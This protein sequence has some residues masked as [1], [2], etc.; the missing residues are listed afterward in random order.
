MNCHLVGIAYGYSMSVRFIFIGIVF[1]IGSKITVDNK[2]DSQDVFLSIY[3]IFTAAMG[4]GFAMSSVPSATQAKESAATIFSMIDDKSQLDARDYKGKL[5]EVPNGTI[6]FK[7]IN[8]NYPSRKKKVLEGFNMVIP[9]GK[10]IGLVGHS[11]CGK[12]TIT[13]LLLRFYDVKD[14]DVLIDGENINKYDISEL[15]RQ[16][17]FV[18]QEPILFNTSIKE[19]IL[20]GKMDATDGQVR[21]Y[22]E[23][24]N[25]LQFIES[26]YEDLTE[27]EQLEKMRENLREVCRKRQ[28]EK[29]MKPVVSEDLEKLTKITDLIV[30]KLVKETVE[31]ADSKFQQWLEE[32]IEL[33]CSM[34]E[35]ELLN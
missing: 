34:I 22:A 8:F 18:M 17:G 5:K 25:A 32:N 15:R 28:S 3:V 1:Y 12:S 6:E 4:A 23:M 9:A 20:F 2:L 27:T 14:G 21:Q 35:T 29:K 24:A 16:I 13:N 31:N 10:K 19:N 11:G 26:N 33:F 7:N 30:L